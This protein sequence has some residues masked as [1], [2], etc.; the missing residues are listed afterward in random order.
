MTNGVIMNLGGFSKGMGNGMS[1][2]FIYQFDP[3][4]ACGGLVS[5]DSIDFSYLGNESSV[6]ETHS[7][8]MRQCYIGIFSHWLSKAYEIISNWEEQKKYFAVLIP[9]ALSK[10]RIQIIY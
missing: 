8:A 4:K 10:C 7:I 3:N 1:G 2:G 9:K 6:N 5:H